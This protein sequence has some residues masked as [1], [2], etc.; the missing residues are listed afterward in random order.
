M[1]IGG[2]IFFLE[3]GSRPEAQAEGLLPCS[4]KKSP[5]NIHYSRGATPLERNRNK[6]K[7]KTNT[8]TNIKYYSRDAY[9]NK[10]RQF[11]FFA[12]ERF[13][14]FRQFKVHNI[15]YSAESASDVNFVEEQKNAT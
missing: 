2:G 12:S 9:E 1:D 4:R 6:V 8:S 3:Q 10:D 14:K 7:L 11:D 13:Q 15:Q 5:P